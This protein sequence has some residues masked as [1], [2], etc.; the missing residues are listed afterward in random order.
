MS[1]DDD[2]ECEGCGLG[3]GGGGAALSGDVP[4]WDLQKVTTLQLVMLLRLELFLFNHSNLAKQ[5]KIFSQVGIHILQWVKPVL[6]MMCI[7]QVVI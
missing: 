6:L 4:E 1:K 2:L 5:Q 7:P 3:G